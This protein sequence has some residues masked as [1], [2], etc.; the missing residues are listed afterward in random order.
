MVAARNL[1]ARRA[2][3]VVLPENSFREGLWLLFDCLSSSLFL[4]AQ[5][6]AQAETQA[7]LHQHCH[8]KSSPYEQD[9]NSH[10]SVLLCC[11]SFAASVLW[12]G[13][14]LGL[15]WFS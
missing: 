12:Q 7:P 14:L 9:L 5:R 10:S 8:V 4:A 3:V 6:T 13:F 1:Q 11:E 2:P 15:T